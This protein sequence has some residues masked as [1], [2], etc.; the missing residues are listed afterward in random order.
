MYLHA[1]TSV[2]CIISANTCQL[3][4]QFYTFFFQQVN[5]GLRSPKNVSE[6]LAENYLSLLVKLNDSGGY[7]GGRLND[8][9]GY[10]Y[11]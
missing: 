7:D 4:V 9:G 6:Q 10:Y 5:I 3:K 8:S 2:T 11:C 1:N